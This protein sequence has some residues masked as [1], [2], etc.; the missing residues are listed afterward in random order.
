MHCQNLYNHSQVR[1][2]GQTYTCCRCGSSFDGTGVKLC[3]SGNFVC[4]YCLEKDLR[5]LYSEHI[6]YRF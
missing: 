3:G 4:L 5:R 1:L 2:K 6:S